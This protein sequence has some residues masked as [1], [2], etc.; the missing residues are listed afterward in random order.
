MRIAKWIESGNLAAVLTPD[1]PAVLHDA[2]DAY[3]AALQAVLAEER[4]IA[5]D[6]RRRKNGLPTTN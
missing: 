6:E 4:R 2:V 3:W 1:M 5:D